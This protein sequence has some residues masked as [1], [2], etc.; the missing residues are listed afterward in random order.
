MGARRRTTKGTASR[1]GKDAIQKR[2]L[3]RGRWQPDLKR[4]AK[5]QGRLS[6]RPAPLPAEVVRA[7][8]MDLPRDC[9]EAFDTLTKNECSQQR[10]IAY[11]LSLRYAHDHAVFLRADPERM[12]RDEFRSFKDRTANLAKDLGKI[13]N[14]HLGQ[15]VVKLALQSDPSATEADYLNLP[16]RL[17]LFVRWLKDVLRNTRHQHRA[18]YNDVL[19]EFL[20][21]VEQL[22]GNPNLTPVSLL[23]SNGVEK[24]ISYTDLAVF[25]S[26]QKDAVRRARLR[27]KK[28]YPIV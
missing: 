17:L 11:L 25:R 20:V 16:Q 15:E 23:V 26:R 24:P 10:L 7:F 12:D 1:N 18:L 2:P 22:T 8:Y 3:E 21:Y 5:E 19:A 28:N 4:L 27:L 6:S 14:T 13:L 9:K